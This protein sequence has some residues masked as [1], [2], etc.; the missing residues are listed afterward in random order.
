[1]PAAF[2]CAE[3]A[4]APGASLL[5][6]LL[7]GYEVTCRL[8]EVFRG[9]Q[10]YHGVHPTA[11]CGVFGAAAAAGVILRLE[12]DALVS[13]LGIAG[14]QAAGLTEWRSDGSWIKRLH[15]G[16]AAQ[17]GV[18]AARL[19]REGF[20]GPATIFEGPGGF[21]KVFSFGEET[22]VGALARG[23]GS[24]YRGL[25]T[26]I[27]PYPCCR[28][29]HGA[30]DLALEAAHSG[31]EPSD[32]VEVN[33]RLYRTDV[34]SY[35]H[36]PKNAVDAQFNVPYLVAVALE[37][38][39][40]GLDDFTERALAESK[41]LELAC[42]IDVI[43]EPSYTEQYPQRYP[44]ELTLRL[45]D[46]TQRR[47]FNDCPSGDPA[48]PRYA[49]DPGILHREVEAKVSTLLTACGFED[50]VQHLKQAVVELPRARDVAAVSAV[51]MAPPSH[52][53]NIDS[54]AMG[55]AA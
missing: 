42:R 14:T 25:G 29:A 41:V 19:A 39:A 5:R 22:D 1:V 30:I 15:P 7:V 11:L 26:A 43:E 13:A 2:A 17:S 23:L 10:F 6:A 50:R 24:D 44:T 4:N 33:V 40:I 45:R 46:G 49:A 16:R 38:G 20:T 48:G 52:G 28:F 47:L 34:L 51:L 12:P 36:K 21:L 31:I 18:L 35:H 9:S 27:K 32:I 53:G 54:A 37:R 3:A 55:S 8:G